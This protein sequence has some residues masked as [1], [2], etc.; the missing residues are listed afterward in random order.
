MSSLRSSYAKIT[1]AKR[2]PLCI[3]LTENGISNL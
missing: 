2:K 1:G 3:D